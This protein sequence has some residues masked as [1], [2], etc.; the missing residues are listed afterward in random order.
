LEDES[1]RQLRKAREESKPVTLYSQPGELNIWNTI[2]WTKVLQRSIKAQPV[3]K[4]QR[5]PN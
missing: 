2:A 4:P 3:K 1:D 5:R